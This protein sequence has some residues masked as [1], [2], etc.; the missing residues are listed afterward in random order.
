MKRNLLAL[1]V[2]VAFVLPLAAQAAPTVYGRLNLSVDYM[3]MDTNVAGTDGK[4]WSLNSNASRVG[5]KGNEKL[6]DELTAV[7]KAEWEVQGDMKSASEL[8]ARERYI[9]LKHYQLGTIRLGYIDSPFKNSEDSIDIF[10]DMTNLDMGNFLHGQTRMANSINYVSPKFLDVFGANLTLQPGEKGGNS[11]PACAAATPVAANAAGC[12]ED[13]IADAISLA[14]SYEDDSLYLSAAMDKEV[15]NMDA[16]RL[17]ARYKMNDIT[18]SAMFQTAEPTKSPGLGGADKE[19]SIVVSGSYTM[20]KVSLR[21]EV[22]SV[23]QDYVGGGMDD[24]TML[25][26]VGVDYNF[27]QSTKAFANLASGT[28]DNTVGAVTTSTDAM[29]LGFGMETRF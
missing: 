6:T 22:L 25:I 24:E 16:L 19:Q 4:V 5:V 29:F 8:D 10:N 18:L 7:Y 3:D 23:Q 13:H 28:M 12:N 2:G 11:V 9:G 15:L 17:V 21:G 27:T 14:L 20:D 1:A 26:G